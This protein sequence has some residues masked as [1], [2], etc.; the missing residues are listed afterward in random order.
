MNTH[1]HAHT[2]TLTHARTHT[3]TLTLTHKHKHMNTSVLVLLSLLWGAICVNF[4]C[5]LLCLP[6]RPLHLKLMLYRLVLV[7]KRVVKASQ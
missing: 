5:V 7:I 1:T 2:H 3:N 6:Q 4:V